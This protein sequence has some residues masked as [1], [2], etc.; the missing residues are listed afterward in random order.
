MRG[1]ASVVKL[2]RFTSTF[3]AIGRLAGRAVKFNTLRIETIRPEAAERAGGYVLAPTHISHLE[4]FIIAM[5]MRRHVDW[6]AR[7]EFYRRG[8]MRAFLDRAGAFPVHRQGVPVSAI[9]T[10][11]DRLEQ[12]RIVGIFPEGGVAIGNDSVCRGG[13]IKRGACLIA[14]RANVPVLPCVVIGTHELNRVMP[15][16]PF[17]RARLWI[18]FGEPIWPDRNEARK[19][20]R[21]KMARQMQQA[22]QGLFQ[23]LIARFHLD[24]RA[25][26]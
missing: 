6:M 22:Y 2:H 17:R 24:E 14:Y 3:Y 15:W 12:G 8:W 9:R 20:A 26:P 4:P 16:I 7:T 13:P 21:E 23:E 1:R 25:I 5:V 11:L 19:P 10:A 18:A